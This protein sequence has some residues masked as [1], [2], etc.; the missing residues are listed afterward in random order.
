MKP[1]EIRLATMQNNN[2]RYLKSLK[3]F[4]DNEQRFGR[5]DVVDRNLMLSQIDIME[6]LDGVLKEPLRRLGIPV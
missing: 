5:L 1:N 2:A 4:A 6:Q 3:L